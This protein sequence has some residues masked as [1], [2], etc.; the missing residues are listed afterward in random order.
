VPGRSPLR[1]GGGRGSWP[2]VSAAGAAGLWW[3]RR[4]VY[5]ADDAAADLTDAET[6][7][8]VLERI[9]DLHDLSAER[10]R[11]SRLLRARPSLGNRIDRLWKRAATDR[12]AERGRTDATG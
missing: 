7:V 2:G 10:G 1:R 11:L 8:A 3:T 5:R 4:V 6:V 12:P 9:G